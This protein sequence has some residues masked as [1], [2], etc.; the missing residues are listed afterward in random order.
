MWIFRNMTFFKF[1]LLCI[2]WFWV[3]NP[4]LERLQRS[5]THFYAWMLPNP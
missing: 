4:R 1:I 2:V 3:I 5:L